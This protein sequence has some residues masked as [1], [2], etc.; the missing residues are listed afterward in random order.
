MDSPGHSAKYCTYTLME[1]E[2]ND[3]LVMAFV[4]KRDTH[5][6]SNNMESAGFERA[7][8]YLLGKGLDID[9]V[10]TDAHQTIQ[11][12]MS[13]FILFNKRAFSKFKFK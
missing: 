4:D 10:V 5:F 11:N 7:M 12:I 2:S 9:E 8:D 1:Y 3:I 6:I 13:K